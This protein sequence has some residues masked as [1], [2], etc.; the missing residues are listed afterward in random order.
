VGLP[1]SVGMRRSLLPWLATVMTMLSVPACAMGGWSGGQLLGTVGINELRPL[2]LP[3]AVN[4]RDQAAAVVWHAGG[5][6]VQR[7]APGAPFRPARPLAHAGGGFPAVAIDADGA[8]VLAWSRMDGSHPAPEEPDEECCLDLVAAVQRP[9]RHARTRTFDGAW[10][11]YETDTPVVA[12][13]AGRAALAWTDSRG[14]HV[15]TSRRGR[16]FGPARRLDTSAQEE[17]LAV[18]LDDGVAHV[19]LT[20]A[21]GS[22]ATRIIELWRSGGR[23]HRR[24][25]TSAFPAA[26]KP[27]VLRSGSGDLAVL[28]PGTRGSLGYARAGQPLRLKQ[29]GGVSPDSGVAFAS[30]TASDGAV[31]A[32]DAG[33]GA[34][35]LVTVRGDGTLQRH[36]RRIR[37]LRGPRRGGQDDIAL[38][39]DGHGRGVV[40]AFT[41]SGRGGETAYEVAATFDAQHVRRRVL[42]RLDDGLA[43]AGVGASL[44]GD[45]RGRVS[46]WEMWH[47]GRLRTF[48]FDRTSR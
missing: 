41:E 18:G 29:I 1:V 23:T 3:V 32:V 5:P 12:V 39:L 6:A 22:G 19:L 2:P 7:A 11:A 26:D 13:R 21:A 9:G 48:R 42:H 37:L 16:G 10:D 28:V 25:V 35:R 14:T 33:H 30:P 27:I 15:A 17:A 20:R 46:F 36:S 24:I 44:A 31:A 47:G 4:A 34:V 8:A 40:A 43:Q 45:G 38:A